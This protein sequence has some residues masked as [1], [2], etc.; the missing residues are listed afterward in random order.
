MSKCGDID[1]IF[2]A[3]GILHKKVALASFFFWQII[4]K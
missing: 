3:K 1:R 2:G 4:L